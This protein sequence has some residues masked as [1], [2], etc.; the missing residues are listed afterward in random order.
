MIEYSVR[1]VTRYFVTR[2][3]ADG[4]TAGVETKGEYESH[5]VAHQVAYAL[6]KAEHD[7]AG[8]GPGDVNFVYPGERLGNQQS[9][10]RKASVMDGPMLCSSRNRT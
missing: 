4:S 3:S 2:Y 5:D 7:A 8:T 6:C 10:S 1:P 9:G